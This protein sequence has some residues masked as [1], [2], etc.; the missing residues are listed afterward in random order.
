MNYDI[1][2]TLGP[3]STH[4]TIWREMLS[5]GVTGFRLNTSHLNIEELSGWLD[6]L[7]CFTS[8]LNPPPNLVLDLQGSKW[9]LGVFPACSLT[10]GQKVVLALSADSNNPNILP[11]PHLD[12]FQAALLSTGEII[13]ND[14]K[15]RLVIDEIEADRLTATVM[16]PGEL[17]SHKGITYAESS[18]RQETLSTKDLTILQQTRSL[19]FFHYA[20]S[21]VKD[22]AEMAKYRQNVGNT[23]YLIAKIER[24]TAVQQAVK[25]AHHADELWLCRGDLGAESGLREMAK[26]IASFSKQIHNLRVPVLLA[27]QVLEHMTGHP[28]PTRSEVSCIYEALQQ[29]YGGIVLSDETAIGQ[30]PIASCQAAAIFKADFS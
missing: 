14:A 30:Y 13:L 22:A 3:S 10:A 1:I 21:Y 12:F 20:I 16:Q 23:V 26:T 9:R 6:R 15:V 2:A 17:S 8:S 19:A 29:G 28:N 27:G 18:Y 25:I 24:G 5:A 7:S 11:V 4:E